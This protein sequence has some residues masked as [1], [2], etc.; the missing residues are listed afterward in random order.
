[1]AYYQGL[2]I[3]AVQQGK[4]VRYQVN[5]VY[6][7]KDPIPMGTHLQAQTGMARCTL[8]CLFLTFKKEFS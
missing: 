3:Q 8:M 4:P 2:I 7:G 5:N 6:Q 1:M